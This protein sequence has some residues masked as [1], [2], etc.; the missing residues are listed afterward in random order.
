[1]DFR[2]LGGSVHCF[3]S[4][5]WFR[6]LLKGL[7]ILEKITVL[8]WFFAFNCF[9]YFRVQLQGQGLGLIG[10][11]SFGGLGVSL[12]I[13]A[14]TAIF[15]WFS[16]SIVFAIFWLVFRILGKTAIFVWFS[17]LIVLAY[18]WYGMDGLWISLSSWIRKLFHGAQFFEFQWFRCFLKDLVITPKTIEP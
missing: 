2:I 15:A 5:H 12:V 16:L 8:V 4:F 10:F 18:F 11:Q 7:M 17:L 3:Q 13:L 9:S 1:M 14:K 6:D